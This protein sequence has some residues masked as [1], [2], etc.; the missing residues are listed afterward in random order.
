MIRSIAV[1]TFLLGISLFQAD[2]ISAAEVVKPALPGFQLVQNA[3]VTPAAT[4]N[5]NAQF[6]GRYAVLRDL[7]VASTCILILSA[8]KPSAKGNFSASLETGCTDKGMGIFNPVGWRMDGDKL[9]IV[10]KR[11]HE[12]SLAK[13]ADGTYAKDKN[14]GTGKPLI[15]KKL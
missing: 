3:P 1:S 6:A 15:L 13:Q 8:G 9:V 5:P 2:V 10:A 4:A 11:G 7:K 14:I 12:A